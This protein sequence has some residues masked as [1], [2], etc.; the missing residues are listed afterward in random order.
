VWGVPGN[1]GP[2]FG[3]IPPP[4]PGFVFVH[5]KTDK[6]ETNAAANMAMLVAMLTSFHRIRNQFLGV[7]DIVRKE[8][9]K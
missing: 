7:L 6:L 1:K 5:T 2:P 4:P 9:L 8:P 3:Q